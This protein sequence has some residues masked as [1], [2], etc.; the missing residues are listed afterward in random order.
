MRFI[1]LVAA[2]PLSA[3]LAAALGLVIPAA[4]SSN[5][6]HP[7]GSSLV[8]TS[9]ADAGPGSLRDVIGMAPSGTTVDLSQLPC[10]D[11]TITLT[12]GAIPIG[13]NRVVNVSGVPVLKM[14]QA[15]APA[16]AVGPTPIIDGSHNS[17]IFNHD[18]SGDFKLLGVVLRNGY[19]LGPGGCLRSYGDVVM[20]GTT[21]SGCTAHAVN[22]NGQ[23]GGVFV[24]GKLTLTGSRVSGNACTGSAFFSGGGVYAGTL[25][26]TDS[27]VS[28]NTAVGDGGGLLVNGTTNISYS[29]ISGNHA[30]YNGGA[31]LGFAGA[32][33]IVN[34]TISG[35]QSARVGGLLVLGGPLTMASTTIAFNTSTS[36]ISTG[37]LGIGNPATLQST[38]IANNL[39]AGAPS[40]VA[41]QCGVVACSPP[42]SGANNLIVSSR[43]SVPPGTL[44][45]DP[46]LTPL[47]N[48]GGNTLTH[49]LAAG[50]PAIDHGNNLGDGHGLIII[51]QRKEGYSRV[52]GAGPDIGAFE[53]GSGPDRIFFNGFDRLEE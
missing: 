18:G 8:V 41:G 26:M 27:T 2:H 50:S 28:D 39:A 53:Y 48:H 38:L 32:V 33:A 4:S 21:I 31:E 17:R 20:T 37:G 45:D 1:P 29:T 34:S 13:G 7:G 12:S 14:P 6:I 11:S 35:N 25:D 36:A 3:A 46:L 43:V 47:A 42:V 19:A 40:D 22:Y 30:A 9:C 24:A 51:D 10:A 23:G 15:P 16:Q 49:G 52:T 44:S 5:G